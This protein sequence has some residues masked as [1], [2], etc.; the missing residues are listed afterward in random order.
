MIPNCNVI[1]QNILHTE[2]IYGANLGS[3]KGKT[4]ITQNVQ[5]TWEQ[6][7][8]EILER[9]R[10]TKGHSRYGVKFRALA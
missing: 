7:P 1:W 5:T 8:T 10:N 9:H 6:V 3:I 4:K 2:D